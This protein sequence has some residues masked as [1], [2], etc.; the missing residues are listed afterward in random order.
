[1]KNRIRLWWAFFYLWLRKETDRS[2]LLASTRGLDLAKIKR[3]LKEYREDLRSLPLPSKQ[4]EIHADLMYWRER[5]AFSGDTET[6]DLW[7][8]CLILATG[9]ADHMISTAPSVGGP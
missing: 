4:A 5:V 1:M 7:N 3:S 8:R 6:K 2:N 9:S